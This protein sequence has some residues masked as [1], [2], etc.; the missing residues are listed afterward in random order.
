MSERCPSSANPKGRI[1]DLDH[2]APIAF[3]GDQASS[4]IEYCV[5]PNARF[6]YLSLLLLLLLPK[7]CQ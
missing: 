2:H 1:A 6:Y 7:T 4:T 3:V 5:G